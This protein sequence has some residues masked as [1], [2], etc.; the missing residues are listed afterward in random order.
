MTDTLRRRFRRLAAL[1]PL[2][3][4][5]FAIGPATDAQQSAIRL[6]DPPANG[7]MG[8]V[9][10]EAI[11]PVVQEPTA[12]PQ[13]TV[14]KMRDQFLADQPAEERARLSKPENEAELVRKWQATAFGPNGTNICS[15][16]DLFSRP[17]MRT[18][19]SRMAW[20]LDLD[21]P[22]ADD[23]CEHAE[24]TS[25]HGESGIDN[26]EYRVMGCTLEWRGTDGI[27]GDQAVGLRQFFA[28][29]EWTQVLLLRGVDSLQ[30]DEDVEVIYANTPD[31]PVIDTTGRFLPG[32]SFTISDKP[33][34]ER[35]VLHGRIDNG[36]LTTT[37]A[38][39]K[40]AQT[41]GQGG[42]RDIRGNR[43]RYDYRH[44]RLRLQFQSDGTLTGMLGGYKPVFDVI[45]SPG[46]GGVG[47]ALVAGIDCAQY[48]QTLR[49]YADGVR[50]P[51]TGK[52]TAIS[53]AVQLAAVPAFVNDIPAASAPAGGRASR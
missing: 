16:P 47:S 45:Q 21:K 42:A 23:T 9:I 8:F 35:N 51:K 18:V 3:G 50:D 26:Q 13:G 30:H 33:P 15:Q 52:C 20:G 7:V 14:L 53:S 10:S 32:A 39:I 34:R 28:S 38:D 41:W 49:Q 6:P 5:L 11:P 27:K 44:G 31:R 2:G 24:F 22:G 40:L 12:C 43:T 37:P 4:A 19:Q 17:A 36:V 46:I 25:P 48:L 1:L 29:G